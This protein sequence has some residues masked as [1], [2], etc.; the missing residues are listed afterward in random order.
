M[1]L[2]N[3]LSIS[4]HLVTKVRAA[5]LKN[6]DP[7]QKFYHGVTTPPP[8][9]LNIDWPRVAACEV[10]VVLATLGAIFS[11]GTRKDGTA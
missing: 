11:L 9:G 7:P 4:F 3:S 10:F 5:A 8:G 2:D 6:D 1:S